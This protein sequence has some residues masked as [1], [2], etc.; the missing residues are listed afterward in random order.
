MLGLIRE[1]VKKL[2][3]KQWFPRGWE[4]AFGKDGYTLIAIKGDKILG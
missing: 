3:I 1:F 4:N 2:N